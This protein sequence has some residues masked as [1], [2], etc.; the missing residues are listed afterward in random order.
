MKLASVIISSLT[1][2]VSLAN[3]TTSHLQQTPQIKIKNIDYAL[4]QANLDSERFAANNILISLT[5]VSK[6]GLTLSIINDICPH[7]PGKPSC[8]A[9]AYPLFIGEFSFVESTIDSCGVKTL[10][11]DVIL[12]NGEAAQLTLKDF[13]AMTCEIVY[14]A[15]LELILETQNEQMESLSTLHLNA[16]PFLR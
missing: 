6:S 9:M 8:R 10:T 11:S 1:L 16:V 13:R 4:V 14:L 15:D 5:N 3:A 12:N 2:I 7:I